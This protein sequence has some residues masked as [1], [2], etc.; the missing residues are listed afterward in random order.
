[1]KHDEEIAVIETK[2]DMLVDDVEK[3]TDKVAELTA[4]LNKYKGFFGGIML[5]MGAMGTA[6]TLGIQYFSN[7]G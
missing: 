7:R 3:L 6:L 1:M 5:M 4:A 2:V